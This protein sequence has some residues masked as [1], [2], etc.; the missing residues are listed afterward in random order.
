[1]PASSE[2]PFLHSPSHTQRHR[3]GALAL[4]MACGGCSKTDAERAAEERA[5]IEVWGRQAPGTGVADG[6]R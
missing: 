2:A 3:M 6:S 5:K 1:M 4:L